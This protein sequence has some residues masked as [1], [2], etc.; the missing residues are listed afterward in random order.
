MVLST[1]LQS[2]GSLPSGFEAYLLIYIFA[3]VDG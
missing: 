2:V 3:F 1:L